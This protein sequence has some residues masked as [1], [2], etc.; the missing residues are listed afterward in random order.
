MSISEGKKFNSLVADLNAII[1]P[2][3]ISYTRINFVEHT[4]Q[5]FICQIFS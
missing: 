4:H 2:T 3:E 5:S 1:A